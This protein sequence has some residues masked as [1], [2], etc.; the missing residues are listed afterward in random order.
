MA[1]R[2]IGVLGGMGPEA[3]AYFYR[4]VVERTNAATEQEHPRVI[5]DSNP[6][7]PPRPAAIEGR[8][9]S[10][11][12]MMA[13]SARNLEK[14][15]A[16]FIAVPCMTAHYFLHEVAGNVRI[17]VLSALE[18]TADALCRRGR[19]HQAVGILATPALLSTGLFQGVL[20]ERGIR[21][22]TLDT[23][24]NRRMR[25][26]IEDVK[27][28]RGDRNS[29]VQTLVALGK[30]LRES[31]HAREV[32]VACTELSILLSYGR[33]VGGESLSLSSFVD[34]LDVLADAAL[35]RVFGTE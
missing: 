16:D 5:I 8:G 33:D 34:C 3:T 18:E 19:S 1:D 17:P 12:P 11:V 22:A 21:S 4:R 26:L 20:S 32:V 29:H 24:W 10:P 35:R 27:L 7:I 2:V 13:E 6:G 14:A 25:G 31:S 9:A 23:G 15:G 28:R 30:G